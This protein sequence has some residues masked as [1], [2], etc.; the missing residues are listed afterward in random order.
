MITA[1]MAGVTPI[2]KEGGGPDVVSDGGVAGV[3]NDDPRLPSTSGLS[4]RSSAS[5]N[6]KCKFKNVKTLLITFSVL[7]I[8]R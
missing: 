2:N 1:R 8:G 7:I 4:T 6:S 3:Q 5:V